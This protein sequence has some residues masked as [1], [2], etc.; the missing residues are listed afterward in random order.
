MITIGSR[1]NCPIR[2]SLGNCLS[3][4]GFCL[5]VNNEICEAMQ[6]AY[7]QGYREGKESE[8]SNDN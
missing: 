5:A 8:A 6:N 7:W 1:K 3:C 4:G 2:T